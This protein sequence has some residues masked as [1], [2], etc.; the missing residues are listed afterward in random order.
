MCPK[1][2]DGMANSVDTEQ[3]VLLGA[4]LS[5]STPTCLG[6]PTLTDRLD[7]MLFSYRVVV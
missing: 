2:V 6:L 4:V 1:D 5:G 3:T 7:S